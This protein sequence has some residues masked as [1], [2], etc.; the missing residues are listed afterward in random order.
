[1]IRNGSVSSTVTVRC[2]HPRSGHTGP[3]GQRTAICAISS[4]LTSRQIAAE[5]ILDHMWRLAL[6]RSHGHPSRLDHRC[7]GSVPTAPSAD[8]RFLPPNAGCP[9]IHYTHRHTHKHTQTHDCIRHFTQLRITTEAALAQSVAWS[10]Y[11]RVAAAYAVDGPTQTGPGPRTR[12]SLTFQFSPSHGSVS[13]KSNHHTTS[14]SYSVHQRFGRTQKRELA[15]H[16]GTRRCVSV[17]VP[18]VQG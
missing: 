9:H 3:H 11:H 6:H 16:G 14:A 17:L 12:H 18:G 13:C 10:L 1:M 4:T 7:Q 15:V 5:W 8:S 2:C